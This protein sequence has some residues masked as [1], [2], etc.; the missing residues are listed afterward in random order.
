MDNIVYEKGK[1][2]AEEERFRLGELAIVG[3]IMAG[4]IPGS[5]FLAK[6][7]DKKNKQQEYFEEAYEAY[8]SD[9]STIYNVS[10][11][12]LNEFISSIPE[13]YK[14][15]YVIEKEDGSYDVIIKEQAKVKSK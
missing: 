13:E 8:T 1:P 15:D 3:L 9:E 11:E 2:Y 6:D 12:E 4:L 10:K 5:L 14:L 7:R